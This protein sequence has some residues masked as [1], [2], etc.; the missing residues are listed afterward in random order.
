MEKLFD[1]ASTVTELL[2]NQ[3]P[4]RGRLLELSQTNQWSANLQALY[5]F[6][7]RHRSGDMFAA[8]LGHAVAN[9]PWEKLQVGPA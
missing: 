1:I 3:N 2:Q 4:L 5:H 8:T 7:S 9:L 6:V